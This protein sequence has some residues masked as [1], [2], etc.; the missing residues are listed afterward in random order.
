M[1]ERS[2][3]DKAS[4]QLLATLKKRFDTNTH[5]HEGVKWS[6]VESRLMANPSAL[7][8]VHQMEATT[9]EPDVVLLDGQY[10]FFDCSRESPKDRRS[11]CYDRAALNERK[12]AK[13]RTSAMEMAKEMGIDLLMEAQYRA[14]QQLDQFDLKTSS[15]IK[16]PESIRK[17]GGALF[18][19]Y[20]YGS[21]FVYHN[22]ASSYCAARGFRGAVNF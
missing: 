2:L 5:L 12:E 18:C 4:Q 11:V 7:W 17:L 19:D 10:F 8:S 6:D 20:R 9:G 14:L 21:V 13:P 15:W 3:S 22:G 1:T 16:T